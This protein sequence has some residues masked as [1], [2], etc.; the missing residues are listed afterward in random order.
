[1][2]RPTPLALALAAAVAAPAAPTPA[3]AEPANIVQRDDAHPADLS[4][5]GMLGWDRVGVGVQ[6]A[7]PVAP[8]GFIPEVNDAF[9]VEF[10]A[11]VSSWSPWPGT[12]A[13]PGI[14]PM[15][16]VRYQ[17]FLTDVFA[18]YIAVKF[19]FNIDV[20]DR[21]LGVA[22]TFFADV[23]LGGQLTLAPHFGLRFD[24]GPHGG[25]FGVSWMF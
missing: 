13:W 8:K 24:V 16:G 15:G 5:Y 23:A 4:V 12:T 17:F 1:M 3:S 20:A 25:R 19:G 2:S 21:Y 10:G 22:G 7:I 9:Y 11:E 18:P 14:T 6:V